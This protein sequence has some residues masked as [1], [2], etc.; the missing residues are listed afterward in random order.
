M[1]SPAL[2][3]RPMARGRHAVLAPVSRCYS[4]LGGR[5]PTRYSPVCRSTRGLPP[6]RAR[7]AC[8]RHA[9][10]VDSEPGSNSPV[11]LDRPFVRLAAPSKTA[12]VLKKRSVLELNLARNV[13]VH[14]LVFKEPPRLWGTRPEYRNHPALVKGRPG[15]ASG[16]LRLGGKR[17]VY[18]TRWNAFR[19][20]EM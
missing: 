8:V 13:F 16:G 4:P 5:L 19:N 9:A 15:Q 6:F 1:R 12:S 2:V 18:V 11:K 3:P 7:L 20:P 17:A 10:S 14:Y